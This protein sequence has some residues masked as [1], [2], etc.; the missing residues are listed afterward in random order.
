MPTLV[1]TRPIGQ[2]HRLSE[3]LKQQ[4][5]ELNQIQLPLLSI[6]PNQDDVEGM[7]L[8]ELIKKADFAIF[9]SPNAVE[10]GM[11]LLGADWPTHLPIAVVGRGSAEALDRR[12]INSAHGYQ[13]SFPKDSRNWDSEGLWAEINSVP[14]SWSGKQILFLKGAGGRDWLGQQFLDQGATIHEVVTYRRLPLSVESPSWRQVQKLEANTTACIINSSEALRHLV[15]VL[16]QSLPWGPSWFNS[17]TIICSHQRIA[18]A[19]KEAGFKQV[20]CCLSGEE[21]LLVA[22]QTWFNQL[23]QLK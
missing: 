11:R 2:S 10:C 21:H 22:T 20:E 17:V 7:K 8:N 4:L 14:V 1:L 23:K 5:P 9:I 18:Q 3:L 12:G 15:D 6:V 19:A 16:D 13:I